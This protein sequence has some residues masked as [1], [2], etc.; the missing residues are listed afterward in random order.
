MSSILAVG[1][2]A[3]DTIETPFGIQEKVLGGSVN[4]FSLSASYF[5]K[6]NCVSVVGQDFPLNH[7]E[8]LQKRGID[9][10]GIKIDKGNT[11]HWSGKYGYEL[12]EAQTLATH[13][14]VFEHFS[15]EVP[16]AYRNSEFV[17]LGNIVPALQAK[18][19]SQ[20]NNPKFVAID[21]MNFWIEGQRE[22]LIQVISKCHCL[23]INEGELRQL[24]KSFNILTAAKMVRSWGPK[25]LVIKRG[26][27][28]AV[29][30]NDGDVF[31]IPGLPL[32][33]VKDP[34]GA[35]DT[36][37]GGFMGYIASQPSFNLSRYTLRKAIVYGSVMASFIV[38]DFGFKNLLPLTKEMINE[39]YH[40]FV[41]LTAFNLG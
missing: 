11:F 33:E 34:T 2:L 19:L 31:S 36:F 18:V 20:V 32:A 5:S 39:R 16:Q 27:Y 24:T 23:I 25:L 35:G 9:T 12:H 7:L 41:E 8:L 38:Q 17:F 10:Q 21:T 28:G 4:H 26:E 14:N 3:F 40:R 30:F 15:P 1:S 29:L 37:A 13:L 6:V 22:D